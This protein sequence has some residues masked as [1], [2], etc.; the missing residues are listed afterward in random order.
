[1]IIKRKLISGIVVL[2]L[3]VSLLMPVGF[4]ENVAKAAGTT[5]VEATFDNYPTVP[6]VTNPEGVVGGNWG[7]TGANVT[8]NNYLIG[9]V[10][11]PRTDLSLKLVSGTG[12]DL[13][14][15]KAN[16]ELQRKVMLEARVSVNDIMHERQVFQ[17]TADNSIKGSGKW[18]KPL[19]L[20][21]TGR[22]KVFGVD[23]RSYEANTWY[24]VQVVLDLTNHRAE[25][26]VDGEL[27]KVDSPQFVNWQFIQQIKFQ[28]TGIEGS[29]GEMWIDDVKVYEL[30]DLVHVDNVSLSEETITM[31]TGETKLLNATV[32]PSEATNQ[33][34]TWNSSESSIV[35]VD[36]NGLIRAVND[37]SAVINVISQDNH[38]AFASVT[39]NV[40]PYVE[41]TGVKLPSEET[42]KQGLTVKL[43]AEIE[44]AEASSAKLKWTSSDPS[45]ATVDDQ[46]VVTGVSRGTAEIT[47]T[48]EANES[49][50]ATTQVTVEELVY[51]LEQIILPE[52]VKVE[53]HDTIKLEPK[54]V[55]ANAAN[56]DVIWTS[57]NPEGASVDM[58]GLV[59]GIK[60][61]ETAIITATSVKNENITASTTIHVFSNDPATWGEMKKLQMRWKMMLLDGAPYTGNDPNITALVADKV[62]T[63]N[64]QAKNHWDKLVKSSDRQ[65]LWED[66]QM[67]PVNPDISGDKGNSDALSTWSSRLRTMALAYS[68]QDGELYHNSALLIDI[69]ESLDWTHEHIY[70]DSSDKY[71]NW[72][73]W[74]IGAPQKLTDVYILLADVL[75]PTQIE[76]YAKSIDY[77]VGDITSSSFR[78]VGA[79]RSDILT[80]Q[81]L[82][83][84][85]EQNPER[86]SNVRDQMSPL[87]TYVTSG[88][89]FYADGS[90]IQHNTIAYT[91]SYGE[92][93]IRGVGNLLYM[94]NGSSW[95]VTDPNVDNVYNWVF[96]AFAPVMY[97]GEMMD[98]VR[99]RAIARDFLSGHVAAAGVMSGIAR[100]AEA[101]PPEHALAMKQL[102][103]HWILTDEACDINE[104][105]TSIEQLQTITAWLNDPSIESIGDV[106][107]HFELNAMNRSV[108][109][110]NDYAFGVSK[111]SK[112]IWTYELTN[113]ENRKGW[114]TG[115]GMTYLYNGDATQ[116]SDDYWATVDYYRLPGTTVVSR[117]RNSSIY[118][119]G[120]GEGAPGNAWAGGTTLDKYGVSGMKLQQLGTTMSVNKSWFMFDDEIV[121]LGSNL[122]SQDNSKVETTIEQRKIQ[123]NNVLTVDGDVQPTTSGWTDS[124]RNVKW[125]HLVGS[126]TNSDI[127]YYFPD[128]QT[129]NMLRQ[130]QKGTWFDINKDEKGINGGPKDER[131][132]NYLTMWYD[133]GV[134]PQAQSYSY[135]LLPNK[136]VE[137]VKSYSQNPNIEI[138]KNEANV[139][140]VRHNDLGI[141]GFNFWEEKPITADFVTSNRQ[142]S[143]MVRENSD[144]TLEVAVSDPTLE[145]TGIIE[146][147]LDRSAAGIIE[148]DPQVYVSQLHPTIKLKVNVSG[149]MG[150]SFQAKFDLDP[151]KPRPDPENSLPEIVNQPEALPTELPIGHIVATFNEEIE[152]NQPE[153][154][155]INSA[156]NTV[157]SLEK[158]KDQKGLHLQMVDR[159]AQGSAAAS[160]SFPS[161]TDKLELEWK[162]AEPEGAKSSK[163]EL[164]NGSLPVIQLSSDADGLNWYDT[165]GKAH[166]IQSIDPATWYKVKLRLDMK[167][168]TFDVYVDNQLVVESA[169]LRNES[170]AVDTIRF[171]TGLEQ[172]Q[173]SLYVDD[174]IVYVYGAKPWVN[175][176]FNNYETG[177]QPEGW[178]ISNPT[179][180][181]AVSIEE[182]PS[183]VNTS[184][185]LYD[186]D[187]TSSASAMSVFEAQQGNFTVEWKFK[188]GTSGRWPSYEL[189]NGNQSVIKLQSNGQYLKYVDHNNKTIDLI[190]F[191]HNVWHSVKLNINIESNTF[192]IY[193]N[194]ALIRKGLAFTK[195][196]NAIDTFKF[197]TSYG[198][199]NT[200]LY[201][202]DVKVYSKISLVDR[203]IVDRQ[204]AELLVGEKITLQASATPI[205]AVNAKLVWESLN[206]TVATVSENG[207]VTAIA[208]GT[209]KVV[210]R[211][212]DNSERA[213]SL[214][215][216]KD[217]HTEEGN[218]GG[219]N[220]NNEN[221][222]E[223][224]NESSNNSSSSSNDSNSSNSNSNNKSNNSEN[225]TTEDSK[226]DGSDN[227]KSLQFT[228][229]QDHWASQSIQEVVESKW[230]VG[231]PDQTFRPNKVMNR[232]EFTS[233]IVRALGLTPKI[234]NTFTDIEE[235]WSKA[236]V[237]TAAAYG[238]I[239]GIGENTFGPNEA[240]TREQL[241]VI[242]VRALK[243]QGSGGE[244]EFSDQNEI[245]DWAKEAVGILAAKGIISGYKDGTFQPQKP[246]T[247]AEVAIIMSKLMETIKEM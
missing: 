100:L 219:N 86:L 46:G 99:G 232:A 132:H 78:H 53:E 182:D 45:I 51:E 172:A 226:N 124:M 159:N 123:G 157:A 1:M 72:W 147:E 207:E 81:L 29:T 16:M 92:V 37:G 230:M 19:V 109:K 144:D 116:Y 40:T 118:Q 197:T 6:S 155:V 206:P 77:Y 7:I 43:D 244:L 88:D 156:A 54:F 34:L 80:A 3:V 149:S 76:T 18:A 196:A 112:R 217:K 101:A 179:S 107:D 133:H 17:L 42:V 129:V 49:I 68:M 143:V 231:Y 5:Y 93:L 21:K 44:P 239:S 173:A 115:D 145:N 163:F 233:L 24:L 64:E 191:S 215:T 22:M 204:A 8:E 138:L 225:K 167:R 174:V 106:P 48:S 243:L 14:I 89:G 12:K 158:S 220:N 85:V 84:I 228:D 224:N 148:A 25:V 83:G 9:E 241:A 41:V 96:D 36:E 4:Y 176:N 190:K 141:A 208:K 199:D 188:E 62:K 73:H 91:G 202:D 195:P 154:W 79:N 193:V 168:G 30:P 151:D 210:V 10:V 127:G 135:V 108:H 52:E 63:T 234:G 130:S 67:K 35:S 160:R 15:Y 61:G 166:F 90:F 171:S 153:G 103:K 211:T 237:E 94:L 201:I 104:L 192:D 212:E 162:F 180:A 218:S 98:M 32:S 20:D 75:T 235:H 216:V 223:S 247:R 184:M 82:L 69:M 71:G 13:Y 59:T 55:P 28:Q 70:T 175:D 57:S 137:E 65:Y 178:T 161:Q 214:I 152:G 170:S 111:S 74:E 66:A 39:V 128:E 119:H 58:N 11:A 242:V 203:V 194:E 23:K 97:K 56:R 26:Y 126:T 183:A 134:N 164:L 47:A 125:A 165:Q 38:N 238:I 213:Y 181:V 121:A 60:P 245:A 189:F 229:V 209:A 236:D 146:I 227:N 221:S 177:V 142:S 117:D 31:Q 200:F 27:L 150:R 185:L 87:F 240:I 187:K 136:S 95:E 122:T 2:S 102:L 198:S 105:F 50:K 110:R 222:N 246:A 140:A 139:H 169:R 114:Y 186:H 33:A 113:G 131:S 205:D 120:D